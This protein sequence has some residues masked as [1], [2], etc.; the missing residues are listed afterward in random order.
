MA[1]FA[2]PVER[3]VLLAILLMQLLI[4]YLILS[5]ILLKIFPLFLSRRHFNL[6]LFRLFSVNVLQLDSVSDGF[7]TS[8][9][10]LNLLAHQVTSPVTPH[11]S[12]GL[13][14]KVLGAL[15]KLTYVLSLSSLGYVWLHIKFYHALA[16]FA[17]NG[18]LLSLNFIFPAAEAHILLF[19]Y[20]LILEV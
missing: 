18:H 5:L 20:E 10:A 14:L 12:L 17:H 2:R 7:P 1:H 9:I 6:N 8:L 13:P 15:W 11:Y 3:L 16:P 4:D 19:I